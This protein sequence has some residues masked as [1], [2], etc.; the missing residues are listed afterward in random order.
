MSGEGPAATHPAAVAFCPH[1]PLLVS[2]VGA[3]EPVGVRA[4][5][6]AAVTWLAALPIERIVVL[7]IGDI[8]HLYGPGSAGSFTGYG[9]DLSV[10]LPGERAH[11][12]AH[13]PMPL[14]LSVGAW[15]LQQAGWS[16]ETMRPGL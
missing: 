13:T 4:P 1:P 14:S 6:V 15:L 7:G 9:V 3:G 10:C 5:A 8:P 11:G 12:P 16:G 2:E